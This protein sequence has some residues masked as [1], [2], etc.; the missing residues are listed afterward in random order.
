VTVR[1][2]RTLTEVDNLKTYSLVLGLLTCWFITH[3]YFGIGHDSL[4]YAVQAL[5][6]LYPE[7]YKNDIFILYGFQDNYTIFSRLYSFAISWLGLSKATATLMLIGYALWLSASFYIARILLNGRSFWIFL[8]F[9]FTLPGNYG[10]EGILSY[11]E[12]F[13]TPRIF[14]E[15]LTIYSIAFFIQRRRSLSIIFLM[16]A[17][18]F[19][20]LMAGC[21]AIFLFIYG[22]KFRLRIVLIQLLLII[23]I[24][25]VLAGAGIEPFANLLRVMDEHWYQVVSLRNSHVLIGMWDVGAFNIVVFDFSIILSAIMIISGEQRRLL[26]SALLMGISCL[27]FRGLAQTFYIIFSLYRYSSGELFG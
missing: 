16:I 27:W 4:L 12:T 8:V 23:G 14:A 5:A 15:A 18:F 9:L 10:Y 22:H 13:L 24:L 3:P 26:S 19:H 20:P 1:I 6:R 11:G 2:H 21:G 25:F 17:L 7:A